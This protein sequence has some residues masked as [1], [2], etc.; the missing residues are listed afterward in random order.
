MVEMEEPE[1]LLGLKLPSLGLLLNN[2]DLLR[3]DEFQISSA[4]MMMMQK[5]FR[6]VKLN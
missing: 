2:L 5:T 6:D 3:K 1:G 4:V